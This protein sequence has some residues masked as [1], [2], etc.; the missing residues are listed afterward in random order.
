MIKALFFDIDG[1][2]VSFKTHSIPD[3][4]VEALEAAKAKGVEIYIS[5]G[6]PY[7]LINNLG[8]IRHLID[9]YITTN[10]AYCFMG[11]NV[12]SCDP[13]PK[14]EVMYVIDKSREWGFPCMVVGEKSLT[15]YNTVSDPEKVLYV[16]ELLNVPDIVSE[17]PI[18]DVLAQRILQLTP[19]IS[20]E[21]ESELLAILPGIE[22]GRWC[23]D[24]ADFTARGV[25]KAKGLEEIAAYRGLDISETMAFGDG[26]NDLSIIKQSGIG[27]AMGNANEILKTVADYITDD[28]DNNGVYNALVRYNV[29]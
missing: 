29:I 17:L 8:Q 26:G 25:S 21:Q 27:V 9:G 22:S 12:I 10:G 3:S 15:M 14:D 20:Q 18:D 4:T 19:F 2:L 23:P 6:R 16:S 24:F 13:I 5:T 7:P 11:N 1:T 28:I